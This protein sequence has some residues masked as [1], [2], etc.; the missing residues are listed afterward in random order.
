MH[1]SNEERNTGTEVYLICIQLFRDYTTGI[2]WVTKA[3][4]AQKPGSIS[5]HSRRDVADDVLA[6]TVLTSKGVCLFIPWLAVCC[7]S[8][9]FH[10]T[11]LTLC[12]CS[13]NG[14]V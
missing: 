12:R 13:N 1:S 7:D 8:G 10:Y 5:I 11:T 14:N 4:H 3:A 9:K 2:S 6:V